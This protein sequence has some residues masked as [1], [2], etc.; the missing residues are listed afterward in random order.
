VKK[1]EDRSGISINRWTGGNVADAVKIL[2]T[3]YDNPIGKMKRFA[4]EAEEI[5]K[6][7]RA[8]HDAA[9]E[10]IKPTDAERDE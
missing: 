10:G 8:A 2:T 7:A 3:G 6:A 4:E 9:L 1:F 5:A